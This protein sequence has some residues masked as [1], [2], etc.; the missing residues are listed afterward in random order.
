VA[1]FFRLERSTL[2]TLTRQLSSSFMSSPFILFAQRGHSHKIKGEAM[3]EKE[4]SL[5]VG[6][7][8]N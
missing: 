2:A 8:A 1:W 7:E 6:F 3:K 5:G 4:S